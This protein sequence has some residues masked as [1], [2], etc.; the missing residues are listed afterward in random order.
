LK[1]FDIRLLVVHCYITECMKLAAVRKEHNEQIH[2]L[3]CA[4]MVI[5]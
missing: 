2:K 3:C 1:T 4:I 5:K